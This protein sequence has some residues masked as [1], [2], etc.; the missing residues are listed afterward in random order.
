MPTITAV[1]ITLTTANTP[2]QRRCASLSIRSSN[3]I[4]QAASPRKISGHAKV[5]PAVN[6]LGSNWAKEFMRDP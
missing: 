6:R 3:K 1:R 5:S 4:A 2:V